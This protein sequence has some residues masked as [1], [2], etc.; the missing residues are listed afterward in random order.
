MKTFVTVFAVIVGFSAQAT[1]PV[2]AFDACSM[3]QNM[4]LGNGPYNQGPVTIGADGSLTVKEDK[5]VR[6]SKD[7]NIER[8]VYKANEGYTVD[9]DGSFKLNEVEVSALI[10][11]DSQGRITG[12]EKS[13]N[14]DYQKAL[15]KKLAAKKLGGSGIPIISSLKTTFD[16]SK[17][18]CE[19][20]QVI[21]TESLDGKTT[22]AVYFDS[23]ACENI[24]PIIKQIGAAA[25]S[26]CASL[27]D[28][29]SEA[30]KRRG[31]ELKKQDLSLR[32]GYLL[33]QPKGEMKS[34]GFEMA[35]FISGCASAVSGGP[36]G[37]GMGGYVFSGGYGN[38]SGTGMVMSG[39][40]FVM[41]GATGS[42]STGEPAKTV[43]GKNG[44]P[45]A[46]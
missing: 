17:K 46:R 30:F 16:P 1:M 37:F 31:N 28:S 36:L 19:L 34:A 7:N 9:S 5:L 35:S 11:R 32:S 33:G 45:G 26:Q 40:G 27:I 39:T 41:N 44:N 8:L 6:R 23:E 42:M 2:A 3:R 38:P 10:T 14:T 12:I 18:D 25:S 20:D 15:L 22:K 24:A 43:P 4:A 13:M 21:G 29:A